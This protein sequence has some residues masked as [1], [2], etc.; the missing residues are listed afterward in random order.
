M[1]LMSDQVR[2]IEQIEREQK[3]LAAQR[4]KET[5]PKKREE[6]QKD[7][8]YCDLRVDG[9]IDGFYVSVRNDH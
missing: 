1:K 2:A 8:D 4:D 7:I 9:I 5:D 3:A 6:I